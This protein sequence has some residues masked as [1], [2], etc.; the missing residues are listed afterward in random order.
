VAGTIPFNVENPLASRYVRPCDADVEREM[1]AENP[2]R[3]H[4]GSGVL[5]NLDFL[6]GWRASKHRR[7]SARPRT[8]TSHMTKRREF[9]VAL[10][11]GRTLLWPDQRFTTNP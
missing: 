11:R 9:L 4:T 10:S 8:R 1:E 2:A 6:G 3:L 5:T 7:K